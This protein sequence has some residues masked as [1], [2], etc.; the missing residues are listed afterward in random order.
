MRLA[1]YFAIH[2]A[3]TLLCAAGPVHAAPV[4]VQD[5]SGNSLTLPAPALRIVSLAPHTT[6]LLFALGAGSEVVGVS[7]FSDYPEAAGR[8]PQV[9]GS[10]GFDL[11]RIAAL[12]PDLVVIWKSGTSPAQ[13]DALKS[14]GLPVFE[15]EPHD[16]AT[17]ASSLERLGKLAGK[18]DEGKRAASAFRVR[19]QALAARYAHASPVTVF[20]QIW[21]QPLM[22]LN[23]H[24]LA[25]A[26]LA[27]CGGK[28]VFGSLPALA[29]TVNIEAV[30]QAD[31]EVILTGNDAGSEVLA[32][33]KKFSQITA[34]RRDNLFTLDSGILTRGSPRVLDGT[35]AVCGKLD[36]ARQRR[37]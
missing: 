3:A 5:D 15:S 21:N 19:W 28:N 9:G 17:V 24:H 22:T 33:W 4:T 23:D 13:I 14:L 11:E 20:Y 8:L 25:S 36:I 2:C 27:V 18:A 31:P 30:L 10:S 35:E 1:A 16:F 6:E 37:K 32:D 29:P 12:K 34:V 7:Q 26:A